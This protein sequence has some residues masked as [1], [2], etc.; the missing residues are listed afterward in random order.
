MGMHQQVERGSGNNNGGG[1][2]SPACAKDQH[3]IIFTKT[4]SAHV[5]SRG[6]A[7]GEGR[8][9]ISFAGTAPSGRVQTAHENWGLDPRKFWRENRQK[10]PV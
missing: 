6:A 8:V 5:P 1:Q 4:Q 2:G 9:R 3:V 10:T 7:G